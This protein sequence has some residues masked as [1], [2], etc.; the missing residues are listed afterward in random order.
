[1]LI[2]HYFWESDKLIKK[3]SGTAHISRMNHHEAVKTPVRSMGIILWEVVYAV[4][5]MDYSTAHI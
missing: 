4:Y 3:T 2:I 1:M 5:P